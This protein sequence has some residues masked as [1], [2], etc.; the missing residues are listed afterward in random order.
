MTSTAKDRQWWNGMSFIEDEGFTL[1]TFE[2]MW[3]EYMHP[4]HLLNSFPHPNAGC[5]QGKW[6]PGGHPA[7]SYTALPQNPFPRK[8]FYHYDIVPQC[9]GLAKEF[10]VLQSTKDPVQEY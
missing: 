7:D 9:E 2:L 3:K 6:S 8:T 4:R 1:H 10:C 5:T